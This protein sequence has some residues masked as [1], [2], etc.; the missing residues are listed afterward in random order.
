MGTDNE[1]ANYFW[2]WLAIF[3]WVISLIVFA[4]TDGKL[5]W[6]IALV[7][8]VIGF[9]AIGMHFIRNFDRITRK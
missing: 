3:A 1:S 6:N 8:V 9:V 5:L 2:M 7:C 4:F